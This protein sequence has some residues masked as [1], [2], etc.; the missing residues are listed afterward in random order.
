MMAGAKDG[1]YLRDS[2]IYLK[3]LL[4]FSLL[5]SKALNK[6]ILLLMCLISNL[7]IFVYFSI[8]FIALKISSQFFSKIFSFREV[9]KNQCG[10]FFDCGA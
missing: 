10:V 9:R 7:L 6:Y 5:Y 8:F 1:S 3:S 4:L 2:S